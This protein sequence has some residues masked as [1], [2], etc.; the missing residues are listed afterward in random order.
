M[1]LLDDLTARLGALQPDQLAALSKDVMAATKGRKFIPSPGPQTEAWF[2]KADLLMYGGSGG[3]GKSAFIAG[4]ATDEH[5]RSLIIRKH[6]SDLIKGG[7]LVDEVLKFHGSRAGFNGSPPAMLRFGDGRVITFGGVNNPGDEEKFQGQPRDLLAV[8]EATQMLEYQIRFL[9]G[10]VRS[11]VPGQNC[12]TVLAT[13][14]PLSATGD[15]IIGMFRPWLDLTHHNPAKAGELRWYVTDPDGKDFEVDG[16]QP[17]LFPGTAKPVHPMSRTFIPAKLADNPFLSHDT[18][19]A[20]AQDSFPEPLRSAIRDGNFML[21]RQDSEWQVIPTDWIRQAQARW[22]PEPPKHAPMS[23]LAVDIAQG[24]SDDTIL[25]ARYDAWFPPAL[26]FPGSATPT[27]NE[28]AGLVVANRRNA[29]TIVVDVGGGYGGAT[30]MRLRDNQIEGVVAHNGASASVRRTADGQLGFYNYRAEC[31]WRFR[32]ALDPSQD[33]GSS[34]ALP[35][36]PMLVSDLTTP[37]YE[38]T[39]RGIKVETKED[40]V[41]RLGRSTD[42]GDAVVMAWSKGPKVATHGNQW[43]KFSAEQGTGGRRPMTVNLGHAAARRTR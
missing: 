2:C 32:E 16:P 25:Q 13:N 19:Y 27:G 6:Y 37:R 7:G 10:W 8:D 26:R 38:I 36:S 40:V 33:G 3:G 17:Y 23:C 39:Q 28:V 31:I 41:K 4:L 1:S 5:R 35:D 18:K 34:V 42:E 21:S 43:R 20:A 30:L 11:E 24:G 29:C 9:M 22:T 15:W 14:P 12:R